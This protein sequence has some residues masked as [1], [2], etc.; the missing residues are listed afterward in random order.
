VLTAYDLPD[1]LGCMAPRKVL[2]VDLKDHLLEPAPGALI[3]EDL[4]F[5]RSAYSEM[6]ASG[7]LKIISTVTDTASLIDWSFAD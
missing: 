4:A 3:N 7:N 6:K 2:L 5:T 1:L